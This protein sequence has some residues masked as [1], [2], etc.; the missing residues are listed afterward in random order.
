[1][2]AIND[3]HN[4]G[5]TSIAGTNDC[6]KIV[7][8]GM[9]GE[10]RVWRIGRQT[11]IMEGSLKEHRGRVSDIKINKQ[12]T[13]A[14]SSSYDGSAI[15]WDIINNTR[16]MCLFESTMFK[17]V[18]YH[19]DESQVLTTGSNRKVTYWDCFDGQ[20]I[21]MLDGSD[22]GEINALAITEAG[23][24]FISGGQDKRVKVWDYDEG[25]AYYQG[26]GHSG[27]ICKIS[28]A[29][30]QRTIVSVGTEGAIFMW[31]MPE[32]VILGKADQDMP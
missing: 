1:M 29:P 22:A 19:P 11:Q 26:I 17:Q 9:E 27:D 23:E 31:H 5:V 30:D 16:V 8:G 2:F 4:H 20:A 10:V 13:Q 32:K 12:D 18:L 7:S 15:I 21:R 14:V 24:H 25:I 6:Q 28:I 3:A